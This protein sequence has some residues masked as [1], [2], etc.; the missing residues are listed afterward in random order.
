MND[1]NRANSAIAL[2]FNGCTLLSV[3]NCCEYFAIGISGD[4]FLAMYW[5]MI[6]RRRFCP[7]SGTCAPS[8]VGPTAHGATS[9]QRRS[10]PSCAWVR[11]VG[12]ANGFDLG[13]TS[14]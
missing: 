1:Y 10:R 5:M 2:Y 11:G 12:A 6:A 9:P 3:P 4:T 13:R 7:S 14:S 8:T